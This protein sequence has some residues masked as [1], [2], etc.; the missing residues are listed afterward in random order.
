MRLVLGWSECEK[1]GMEDKEMV[2]SLKG[3]IQKSLHIPLGL[4]NLD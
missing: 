4:I 1:E 3:R 2:G